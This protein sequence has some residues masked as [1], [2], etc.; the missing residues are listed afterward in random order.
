MMTLFVACDGHDKLEEVNTL[1]QVSPDQTCTGLF[2]L[3]NEQSGVGLDRCSL[4][5]LC[6]GEDHTYSQ[7]MMTSEFFAYIHSNPIPPL[8]ANPYQQADALMPPKPSQACV[9]EMNDELRQYSLQTKMINEVTASQITHL[10]ACGACSSLQDLLVYLTHVD[11][12][13]P[14]RRCGLQ[15]ITQGMNANLECLSDL[16]FSESCAVIWY[17]NTLNTRTACLDV[18]LAQ[19]NQ[20]YLTEMGEL[21]ECLDCDERES[22]PIFKQYSGRTRRN[23]G[24]A[25][26]I[27]R[28]CDSVARLPH[29]YLYD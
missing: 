19:L 12:T 4:S 9:I 15:G 17:Y 5:C 29:D 3:P 27:C 7:P 10:G 1:L 23:S 21:N 11:L 20:P 6:E 16:G 13:D 24:L 26:A 25:S 14:V 2:G 8:D 28:P 22:G 18:C